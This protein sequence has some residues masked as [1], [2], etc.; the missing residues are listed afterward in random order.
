M[1]VLD[2][3]QLDPIV[4]AMGEKYRVEE[5]HCLRVALLARRLFD[6]LAELHGLGDAEALLLRHGAMLHDIGHFVSYRAH[7]RHSA[8]LIEHDTTLVGYPEEGRAVLAYLA[9][10][11]RKKPVDPPE[12]MGQ[13]AL[14]L[15]ALLR[16][17]DGMDHDRTGSVELLGAEIKADRIILTVRGLDTVSRAEV[18]KSKAALMKP[19]FGRKLMWLTDAPQDATE[20]GTA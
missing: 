9:R 1:P 4:Q 18:L 10:S 14:R 6:L 2:A 19:A 15:A 5:D 17:A 3:E 11:H 8:Y 13:V 12:G 20:Q 16:L 7:H